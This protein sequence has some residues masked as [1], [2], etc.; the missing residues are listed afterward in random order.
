[1]GVL[2]TFSRTMAQPSLLTLTWPILDFKC[3]QSAAQHQIPCPVLLRPH[4]GLLLGHPGF[5]ISYRFYRMSQPSSQGTTLSI[6][7]N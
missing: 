4:F 5:I 3:A 7:F 1:M 2:G 6:Q